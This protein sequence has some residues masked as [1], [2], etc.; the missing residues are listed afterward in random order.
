MPRMEI[1]SMRGRGS[2]SSSFTAP[3]GG[4]GGEG[5]LTFWAAPLLLRLPGGRPRGRFAAGASP[6]SPAP[7]DDATP[8]EPPWPPRPPRILPRPPR[9][10]LPGGRMRGLLGA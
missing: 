4:R 10:P 9:L 8:G 1:K 2:S 7:E 5:G 3:C 6:P